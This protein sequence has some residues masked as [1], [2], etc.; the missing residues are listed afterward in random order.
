MYI[1]HCYPLQP[2]LPEVRLYPT[3][4]CDVYISL[5][6]TRMVNSINGAV[7]SYP[8]ILMTIESMCNRIKQK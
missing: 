5:S 1:V 8:N 6:P 4:V 3:K 7:S 2:F